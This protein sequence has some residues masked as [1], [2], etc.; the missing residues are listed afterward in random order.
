MVQGSASIGR[1]IAD[2]RER[3]GFTQQQL[4]TD[5]G[6]ARSAVAKIETGIRGVSALELSAIA[7]AMDMSIDWLLTDGPPGVVA[8]RARLDAD[9]EFATIDKEVERFARDVELMVELDPAFVGRTLE[10]SEIPVTLD[11]AED[12]AERI[13]GQMG[14]D[15][16]EPVGQLVDVVGE[17]GLVAFAMPLGSETADAAT[18]LLERGAVALINSSNEVGRRR[19]ALAHELGHYVVADDYTVDW[20]VVAHDNSS[21]IESRLD[22]FARAI[23]LPALGLTRAWTSTRDS[24]DL[25]TTA[26]LLASGFRVDM[27]TLARRLAELGVVSR[28]DAR[29]VRQVR[30]TKSDIVELG[31]VVAPSMDGI[32]L[33][34]RYERAV[35]AAFRSRRVSES[36]ALS[37]LRDTFAVDDLPLLEPGHPNEIWSIVA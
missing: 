24:Y 7:A 17:V 35:L 28:S 6:L 27:S 34:R 12:L 13:R 4:S 23:L 26:V 10:P 33:P 9:V 21:R 31:L 22:R 16:V 19:L 11:D 15:A 1:R 5:S 3:N 29:E 8:H 37:L 2:A 18:V 14:L 30:T 32:A 20:R 36:R 25:R